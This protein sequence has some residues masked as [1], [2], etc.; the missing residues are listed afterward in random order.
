MS[1]GLDTRPACRCAEIQAAD[2]RRHFTGCSLREP[3]VV[4]AEAKLRERSWFD[5]ELAAV[6]TIDVECILRAALTEHGPPGPGEAPDPRSVLGDF[7]RQLLDTCAPM[8]SNDARA[9][10]RAA[11]RELFR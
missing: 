7:V 4:D 1:Q 11:F 10:A 2:P 8:P 6:E 5:S 9:L 3:L